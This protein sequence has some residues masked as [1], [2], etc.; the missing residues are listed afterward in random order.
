M[1]P[2]E[3]QQAALRRKVE[4]AASQ[5]KLVCGVGNNAAWAVCLE[6]MDHL[7][8]HPRFRHTVKQRF[9]EAMEAFKQYESAL[10]YPGQGVRYFD[11][12]RWGEGATALA[13]KGKK[14]YGFNGYKPGTTEWDVVEETGTGTG[15]ADKWNILPFP[16]TQL[17][18]NPELTQNPGW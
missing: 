12:V 16:E 5:V 2:K 17:T 6:A 15:W 11:I 9:K 4:I 10:I 3:E 13:D 14:Q 18:A 1:T 8:Q 7:K